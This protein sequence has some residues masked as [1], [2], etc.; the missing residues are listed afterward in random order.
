MTL[1]EYLGVLPNAQEARNALLTTAL[2]LVRSAPPAAFIQSKHRSQINANV[3]II[4]L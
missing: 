4:Q 1:L 3:H 2:L